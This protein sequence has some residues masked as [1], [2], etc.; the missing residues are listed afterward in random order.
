MSFNDLWC[1]R[2][3]RKKFAVGFFVILAVLTITQGGVFGYGSS[4][5][6]LMLVLLIITLLLTKLRCNHLGMTTGKIIGIIV[7]MLIPLVSLGA[8]GYLVFKRG[9]PASEADG[10]EG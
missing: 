6:L 3:N 7:V 9:V 1:Y 4:Y 10:Y 2:L 5:R 8:I